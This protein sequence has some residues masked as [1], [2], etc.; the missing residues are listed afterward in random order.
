MEGIMKQIL[1]NSSIKY[2]NIERI[3]NKLN[4]F[5][6]ENVCIIADFDGTITQG[7]DNTWKIVNNNKGVNREILQI[8]QDLKDYYQP[9][10]N[11]TEISDE[12]K[13]SM[14]REWWIK[15]LNIYSQFELH[16]QVIKDVI[17]TND[18][19][20]IRDGISWLFEICNELDIPV[21]ILSSG[22]SNIIDELL[23]KEEINFPQTF[24]VSNQ[25]TFDEEGF[26]KP[27]NEDLIIHLENKNLDQ[28]PSSILNQTGN[29]DKII[30]LG[31]S[32]KDLNMVPK[33]KDHDTLKIGFLN[34]N[35]THLREQFIKQFDIVIENNESSLDTIGKIIETIKEIQ[36]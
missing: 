25:L 6:T 1:D 12:Q 19:I 35:N 16:K 28:I 7:G 21:I 23:E 32:L 17:R 29:R 20:K 34:D 9:I 11:N 24:I 33:D 13:E 5:T 31:D 26:C 18:E 36:E 2:S 27:I 30:L 10:E 8:T 15:Q 3:T 14:M 4:E 22:I